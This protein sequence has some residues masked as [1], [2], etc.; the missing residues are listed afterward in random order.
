MYVYTINVHYSNHATGPSP[1]PTQLTVISISDDD[2]P[3]EDEEDINN[4]SFLFCKSPLMTDDGDDDDDDTSIDGI[5][6]LLPS[7]ISSRLCT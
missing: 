3:D 4:K 5:S 2:V 7:S 6:P 1:S